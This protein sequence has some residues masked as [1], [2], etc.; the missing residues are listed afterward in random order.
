MTGIGNPEQPTELAWKKLGK[1]L[2]EKSLTVKKQREKQVQ[3]GLISHLM[4]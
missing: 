4:E 2:E 3:A 1:V